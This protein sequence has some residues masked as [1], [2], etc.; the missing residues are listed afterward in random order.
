MAK[1][2][3]DDLDA[4]TLFPVLLKIIGLLRISWAWV[5]ILMWLPRI[6]RP[7]FPKAFC[8][9]EELAEDTKTQATV[10]SLKNLERKHLRQQELVVNRLK[11]VNLN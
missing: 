1:K 8:Y 10:D 7:Y 11:D 6:L 9:K 5:L 2:M 4:I 3:Q